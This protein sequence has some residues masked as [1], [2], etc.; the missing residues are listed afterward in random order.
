MKVVLQNSRRNWVQLWGG[1]S[2]QIFETAKALQDLGLSVDVDE[3]SRPLSLSGIDI[4][5]IFNIQTAV[6]GADLMKVRGPALVLSPIYWDMRHLN[7]TLYRE[8]PGM[9]DVRFLRQLA[10]RNWKL[11]YYLRYL[12]KY[13]EHSLRLRKFYDR[14]R[15]MLNSAQVLLPNSHAELE[16]IVREFS[17]PNLR[18]SAVIV[19]NAVEPPEETL[20]DSDLTDSEPKSSVPRPYVLEVANFSPVKGQLT[21][22]K[23]FQNHKDIPIVLVG[24]SSHQRYWEECN[25]LAG[26]RGNTFIFHEVPHS[27]ISK[28]YQSAKVH[29]LP[30]L[31]ESPGLAT[32]EAAVNGSNCVVSFHGPVSEYFGHDVW[33]CDPTDQKSIYRAVSNAWNAEPKLNLKN[34]IL[35]RFVW[36]KAAMATLDAYLFAM[37]FVGSNST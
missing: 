32:L 10:E 30:S 7:R 12:Y 18:A 35:D 34:R 8:Y 17:M 37:N 16:I 3:S 19:P 33:Y 14:A 27:K 36:Q 28:F 26:K 6:N 13:P 9:Y 2:T 31:R 1:D 11:A 25:R 20:L 29:V 22:I 21:L 23:A 15:F 24:R 5:H 4:L